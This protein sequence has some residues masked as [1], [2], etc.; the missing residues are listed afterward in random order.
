[1]KRPF[2]ASLSVLSAIEMLTAT[3]A[4]GVGTVHGG[5]VALAGIGGVLAFW[6]FFWVENGAR[7]VF[8]TRAQKIVAFVLLAGALSSFASPFPAAA[9]HGW[10]HA[11]SILVP[12]ALWD[13]PAFFRRLSGAARGTLPVWILLGGLGA[14]DVALLAL[15]LAPGLDPWALAKYN[16]GLTYALLFLWP[17]LAGLATTRP[18]SGKKVTGFLF[19]FLF[20]LVPALLCTHSRAGQMGFG[21]A[22]V[23]FPVAWFAP[24]FVRKSLS[25][26]VA[27]AAAWPFAARW[28][29]LHKA[30]WI[31]QLP[32]SWRA[33]VEIWDYLSYRIAAR[34]WRGWGL[35][36]VPNLSPS[37]PH[38]SFYVF[39]AQAPAHAHNFLTSLWVDLGIGGLLGGV[40]LALAVLA[41]TR[42]LDRALQPFA[43]AAFCVGLGLALVAYNFWTDSL[44]AAFALTA[45]WFACLNAKELRVP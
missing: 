25:C 1:M 2:R 39:T 35:G 42:R 11:A 33:R 16:R 40:A 15:Y 37:D 23:L 45:V 41:L 27:L 13:N 14:L 17:A 3:L 36:S 12:L 26:A 4:L 20:L 32:D 28:L 43:L 6:L 8:W 10:I 5:V 7:P 9:W 34:P 29:F 22:L 24:G 19:L 38:G 21:V 31:A 30:A 18:F 44:L